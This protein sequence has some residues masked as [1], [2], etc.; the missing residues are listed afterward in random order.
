MKC[1]PTVRSFVVLALMLSLLTVSSLPATAA[2]KD[3]KAKAKPAGSRGDEKPKQ[4]SQD[5]K[6]A[7]KAESDRGNDKDKPKGDTVSPLQRL[8]QRL[9]G[10]DEKAAKSGGKS[11]KKGKSTTARVVQFTLRGE[12]P[13]GPTPPGLFAELKPSLRSIVERMDAAAEDDQVDAVL[14]RIAELQLG[15]GKIAELRGAIKRIREH[16]KPVYASLSTAQAPEYQL[17]AACDQVAI[18]PGGVLLI[19]GVSAEVTFL[20]GLLEKIGIEVEVLQMGKYKGAGEPFTRKKLSPPMRESLRA[21]VD[22]VYHGFVHTVAADRKMPGYKVKTLV[23]EGLFT[24]QEARREGLVDRTAYPDEVEDALRKHL[25]ADRLDIETQYRRKKIDTELSGFSGMMKLMELMLGGKPG[26]VESAKPKVA[27]VYVVG[28]IIE[29]RQQGGMFGSQAASAASIVK[30]LD[31]AGKNDKIKAVVLRVDS[32][33]GSA[34]A[35]DLIWRAVTRLEK[36]VIASMGDTA[37]SGGYY[38]AM[39]ADEIIA[40]PETLTGSIG[41][42]GGKPVVA[43]LY[44]KLGLTKEIISRGKNSGPFSVTE[45]FSKGQRRQF[46]KTLRAMYR[47]FV[48]KAA[49]GRGMEYDTLEPLAQ[50]RIYSGRAA[51]EVGLIDRLG[52][53]ADAVAAA[54]DAAGL[55]EDED[56]EVIVLPR[57]KSL[58]EQLFG[59]PT[60]QSAVRSPIEMQLTATLAELG[61]PMAEIPHLRQIFR[62]PAAVWMPYKIDVR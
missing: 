53:L 45:P 20:T 54:R 33:G 29:M 24:A 17:A 30:A 43:G 4:K 12:Y 40:T 57:P 58:L 27:I 41:V 1:L 25:K 10:G 39:G 15:H 26:P 5:A 60:V 52:T 36:P 7:A 2:A 28:P 31:E 50:G 37:A 47:E 13:E 59:G 8:M 62:H 6:P 32:P 56:I 46:Q 21:L 44:E 16:G 51:A 11:A 55:G 38:V 42:V 22:D 49:R 9:A 19:P 48:S 35:S 61:I 14:L 3:Q 18:A 34:T 23:D